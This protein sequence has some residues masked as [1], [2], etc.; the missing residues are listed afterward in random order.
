METRSAKRRK[1]RNPS[2]NNTG[3]DRITDLPDAV[4]HHILFLLP[5]KSIVQTSVLSKRWRSLWYAFPDLDFTTVI[6]S[7]TALT[8][9][10][11]LKNLGNVITQILSLRHKLS[12]VRSLRFC[13]CMTFSGLHTLVRAAVRL[14]VQELDIRVA[15]ND[16]INFPRSIIRSDCLRVLKVRSCPGLRL[17][18]S[19]IMRSG[20][21]TLQ[22]LSL[23]F[24][25]LDNQSCLLDMFTDGSFPQLR[26][27][28][29]DSCFNL[30]HLRVGCRLLEEL[31]LDNC[32]TLQVLEILCPRLET[33]RVSSCFLAVNIDN[34]SFQIDAP[35]LRTMVWDNSSVTGKSCMQNLGCLH[36]ATIGFLVRPENLDADKLR[37]V[38]SFLSGFSHAEFLTLESPFVEVLHYFEYIVSFRF[39][40]ILNLYILYDTNNKY[41]PR[42][43]WSQESKFSWIQIILKNNPLATIF[44]HPFVKLKSLELHTIEIRGL[45]SLLKVCPM[46][47]TLIIKITN[48]LKTERRDAKKGPKEPFVVVI[49]LL[50][51]PF[52]CINNRISSPFLQWNNRNVWDLSSSWE[53][54]YWESQT[55]DLK[56]LLQF[57]RVVKIEGFFEC[58]ND[59][60]ILIKF[61]LKHG[62]VLQDL[63]LHPGDY[64]SRGY[65]RHEK[66][67][68]RVMG[69]SRASVDAK[70][71]FR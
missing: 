15:T 67:K 3:E 11:Y 27:L 8:K 54:Q 43:I 37:S 51:F 59:I 30:K 68:S 64:N 41:S 21:R 20:F 29:L 36:E 35:R 4:L 9:F 25:H 6:P 47:H 28:N 42:S 46:I 49:S 66:F 33:L 5:I 2:Q 57:L 63:I 1:L 16:T 26:K 50:L 39:D 13:A 38:S 60:M 48:G 71:A 58:E 62:R 65:H 24:V 53:E 31:V 55:D 23:S 22:T 32:S 56:P 18:P 40:L 17:P 14:R 34:T 12:D 7:G 19:R 10:V 44:F 69:F 61:L 52:I 45:A 70:L